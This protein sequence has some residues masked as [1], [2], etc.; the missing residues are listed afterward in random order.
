[1]TNKR[2]T[3][4]V[5]LGTYLA[6]VTAFAIMALPEASAADMSAPECSIGGA[7][8]LAR[9]LD[10]A[11]EIMDKHLNAVY[12]LIMR[13][14][15]EAVAPEQAFFADKKNS[16]VIAERAWIKF[17]D[18]H[19]GAEVAFRSSGSASGSVQIARA[20]Y[21][22]LTQERIAYLQELV[23]IIKPDSKLCEGNATACQIK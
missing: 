11:A 12:G 8:A 23:S 9:C 21:A 13:M 16:L 19:C 15:D 14:L 3:C 6:C 4:A 2:R 1:M 7:D 5:V 10:H 17:R 18:A 20:C 22:K